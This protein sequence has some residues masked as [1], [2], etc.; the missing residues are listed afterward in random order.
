MPRMML[1]DVA[2]VFSGK[3]AT[4]M[5]GG[6]H[7]ARV[8]NVRDLRETLA[9]MAEM[10][11]VTVSEKEAARLKVRAGDLIATVRG[12]F[13][14]AVILPEH[15]GALAGANTAVIRLKADV[16]PSVIGAFLTHPSTQRFLLSSFV[17]STVPGVSLE[18]IRRVAF[19]LPEGMQLHLLDEVVSLTMAY[20]QSASR[21]IARRQA[22]SLELVYNFLAEERLDV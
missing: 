13:Q 16:P 20:T 4:R 6:S 15:E 21:S 14:V 5:L 8:I 9:P 2:Q 7:E 22:L 10:D 18:S 3:A 11:V 1:G 12:S 17:G 19:H